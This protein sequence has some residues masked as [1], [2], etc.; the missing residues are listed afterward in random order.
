MSFEKPI[1]ELG[2]LN[3]DNVEV[4]FANTVQVDGKWKFFNPAKKDDLIA[5]ADAPSQEQF[6]DNKM[7]ILSTW[8]EA[9]QTRIKRRRELTQ[10]QIDEAEARKKAKNEG[11]TVSA[12]GIIIPEGAETVAPQVEPVVEQTNA[13]SDDPDE[14]IQQKIDQ[15]EKRVKSAKLKIMQLQEE[16]EEAE[17]DNEKAKKDV[18]KWK[19]M[20]EGMDV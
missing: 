9:V 14:F 19:K 6:N 3:F 18:A 5:E 13:V 16:L 2:G 20:K 7:A 4:I 11:E 17:A 8:A 15:A 10:D 1:H 12:G